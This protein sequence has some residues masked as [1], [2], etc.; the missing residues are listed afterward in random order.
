MNKVDFEDCDTY[1]IDFEKYEPAYFAD[2]KTGKVIHKIKDVL[3]AP[4]DSL[5]ETVVKAFE[6]RCEDVL[7]TNEVTNFL[8]EEIDN[9][10]G[11]SRWYEEKVAYIFQSK[12]VGYDIKSVEINEQ[13]AKVDISAEIKYI[14]R[15][16]N[17]EDGITNKGTIE[18]RFILILGFC[19]L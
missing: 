19:A 5:Q 10:H 4:R 3:I 18:V 9:L 16:E 14:A 7:A 17:N 15:F 1:T 6:S 13:H 12:A 8:Q 2:P 11:L